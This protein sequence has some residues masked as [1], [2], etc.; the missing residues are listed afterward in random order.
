MQL[1]DYLHN[2]MRVSAKSLPYYLLRI[3]QFRNSSDR[4]DRNST[5]ANLEMT[6]RTHKP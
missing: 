4:S 3:N 2:I 1:K 6:E 5:Q